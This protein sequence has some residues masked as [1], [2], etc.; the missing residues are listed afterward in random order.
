MHADD[1]IALQQRMVGLVL[2]DPGNEA[3]HQQATVPA[4]ASPHLM[5]RIAAHRVVGDVNAT[6][7]GLAHGIDPVG[8]FLMIDHDVGADIAQH[9]DLRR[10]AGDGDGGR[11]H[12]LGELNGR[13]T[14]TARSTRDQHGLTGLQLGALAK[15][16]ERGAVVDRDRCGCFSRHSIRNN[17]DCIRGVDD[18]LSEPTVT[19]EI[20]DPLANLD[21]GHA[22]AKRRDGSARFTARSEPGVRL[23]LIHP[24]AR[25]HVG[26]REA[27]CFLLNQHLSGA[28]NGCVFIDQF[29]LFEG[30]AVLLKTP[31]LHP[32]TLRDLTPFTLLQAV[33]YQPHGDRIQPNGAR[34]RSCAES[35]PPGSSATLRPTVRRASVS[36]TSQGDWRTGF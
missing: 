36:Y 15:R 27:N 28:R 33:R 30:V 11:P 6:T 17:E 26:K 14:G 4:H 31:D 25:Q 1:R 24:T 2:R 35:C 8:C 21:S 20:D 7:A 12:R 29:E 16:V 3:D 32:R 13:R 10:A 18:L 34:A 9:T 19:P 22:I 5:E 23:H